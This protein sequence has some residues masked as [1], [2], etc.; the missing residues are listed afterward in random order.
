[1][2]LVYYIYAYIRNDG[3]PYYIGK[4]S[5]NRAYRQHRINGRGVH[6]PT[7]SRIIILE[8]NLSE[9]GANALER[10]MIRWWGRKDL[11]TGILHNK[12]DG[13]DGASGARWNLSL[14]T[15]LKMSKGKKGIAKSE[16]H[17][18]RISEVQLGKKLS[19]EHKQKISIAN[20]GKHSIPHSNE[21]QK[22]ISDS[23]K[24]VTLSEETKHKMSVSR[25]G[26]PKS[27]EHKQKIRESCLRRF[28]KS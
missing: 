6:T 11:G 22:K 10:R 19:D 7:L 17:K 28:K 23:L 21:T 14:E 16:K 25:K 13:G 20:L 24:G 5:G 18:Q 4:G 12:T 1:M 9:L 26:V 15:K 3:T 2:Y 8:S 27:E